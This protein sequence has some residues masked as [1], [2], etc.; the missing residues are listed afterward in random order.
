MGLHQAYKTAMAKRHEGYK[1]AGATRPPRIEQT[2]TSGT[3]K[4]PKAIPFKPFTIPLGQ[5][6]TIERS[7]APGGPAYMVPIDEPA[8]EA[9]K[10]KAGDLTSGPI[11]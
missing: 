11:P 9:K 2:N 5:R 10:R 7:K 3:K 6:W 4:T 8:D 1:N